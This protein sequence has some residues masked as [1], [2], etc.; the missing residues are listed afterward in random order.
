MQLDES[1]PVKRIQS[2]F[3][4]LFRKCSLILYKVYTVSC[5]LS[6]FFLSV[7]LY[8]CALNLFNKFVVNTN[9]N[10]NSR[11]SDITA[12]KLMSC[13]MGTVDRFRPAN[14]HNIEKS[15]SGVPN[16]KCFLAEKRSSSGYIDREY[17]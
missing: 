8:I 1:Q 2:S 12:H 5:E 3:S 14:F 13:R 7:L 4:L 9:K 6:K 11:R 16:K 10:K 15:H 17:R